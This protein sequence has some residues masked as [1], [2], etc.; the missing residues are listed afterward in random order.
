MKR[1]IIKG[2]YL[3]AVFGIA[4][5][6]TSNVMNKGN[7]DMTTEMNGASFPVV[8][9]QIDEYQVNSL[10]GYA[11]AM[12]TSYLRDTLLPIEADRKVSFYVDTYGKEIDT[13]AFEV[14]SINGTRLVE[15]TAIENYEIEEERILCDITLKDLINADEEYML[16]L[17]VTPTGQETIRYYTRIIQSEELHIQEKLEYILDF[18]NRTFDR[19]EAADLTKYLESNSEGDNTTFQKVNIHSSF[20]QVTWGDLQIERITE[21][22]VDVMELEE[23]TGSFQLEYMAQARDGKEKMLYH[24]REYYRIRYTP[25]RMYLLDFEREMNQFFDEQAE[26]MANNKIMLGIVDKQVEMKES[27]GGNVFAFVVTNKLYSYNVTDKKLARLFSFYEEDN[28]TDVRSSYNHHNIKILNVD[29][30]GNVEFLVYGYMNRGRHEGEV[31]VSVYSY[32]STANTVE[33]HVY[34]PYNRSYQLLKKD[35]ERLAY[36]N[37]SG[38]CFLMLEGSV[39]AVDLENRDYEII[40]SGLTEDDYTV[41]ESNQ[42]LVWQEGGK[43]YNCTTLKL[44]NLGTEKETEITAGVGEYISLLGFMEED[45]IYG[46]ARSKDVVEDSTGAVTFPMYCL[47]IQSESG[48]LLKTYHE[49]GVYVVDGTITDNQITLSRVEW[50]EEAQV[51]LAVNDDQ[52]MSTEKVE[53]GHNT[54]ESVIVEK[55]ETIVEIAVKEE[56]D[57]KAVKILTP[58][59]VLFEGEREIAMQESEIETEHFYVYGKN[60]IEGTFVQPGKA[61][62]YAYEIAGVVVNDNGDYVWK[63]STRSTKN[64]IMAIEGEKVSEQT[65]SLS[66]CLDTILELEGNSKHTKYLLDQGKTIQSILEDNL[67]GIQ[68]LDLSGCSLDAVLYYV[69]MDIPVLATLQD[70]NAVLIVGFNELNIVLMDPLTGTVYKKGMNDSTQWLEE[71]GNNFITYIR[72]AQE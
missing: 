37:K 30:A 52:I 34:I 57:T 2:I 60:G 66:V 9:M 42:M 48:D 61:V 6:V 22:L 19:E 16:I 18:H 72:K 4:L 45:L 69:N 15:S 68:V 41:S 10:H 35:V 65:S 70:G 71:N 32:S 7:T 17:L 20:Q 46:L 36:L 54:V 14:R 26:I 27:D 3:G 58:K 55:Y 49:D 39:Y 31:G 50:D 38:I 56:I 44:L 40:V 21:P 64:Q 28:I 29:E 24:V 23:Q 53:V 33:E 63:R 13:L 11:E 25:D 51:Y 67:K 62:N 43:K 8:T 12:N 1:N 59:E 47:K 5:F